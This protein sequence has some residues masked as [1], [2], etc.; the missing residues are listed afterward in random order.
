MGLSALGARNRW[1]YTA[2]M[3]VHFLFV[4]CQVGSEATVK[5][6]IARKHPSFRFAFSRRGFLTFR[7]P[8]EV[9]R[10]RKFELNCV[11]AR[12]WG[13][14]F[15]K[16]I[17]TDGRQL[18]REFWKPFVERYPVDVLSQFRHLHV[19]QRDRFVP[20]DSDFEP[21]ITPL[22]E[23]IGELILEQQPDVSIADHQVHE[24]VDASPRLDVPQKPGTSTLRLTGNSITWSLALNEDANV[25]DRILDCVI[26]EPNE[27]WFGWH[28]ANAV[29]TRW[30]GGVPVI[31]SPDNMISRAYLKIEEALRWSELPVQAGDR[32]VEVGSSPGGS[33]Q[34]L[35]DR[36][37]LVTGID[38]AEMDPLL[39]AN[40]NF[41]HLRS[42][43][44]KVERNDF[45]SFRWL[46]MDANVAPKYTL[47]TVE[48]IVTQPS[49][50]IEGLLL[51]LKLTDLALAAELPL[52]HKR[53]RSWGY[54]RVR[55]RQLAFNRQE[56]CVVAT[57]A[58]MHHRRSDFSND[59]LSQSTIAGP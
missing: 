43:A 37:C 26:V 46:A 19:W 7:I 32:F 51:T 11:F 16:A 6:E 39:L 21:G 23:G 18:A 20:G 12:T 53:I 30:P 24:P 52:F 1:R 15:G 5:N 34:A 45:Q 47:D 3:S 13:F 50:H 44:K 35:L 58:A 29:E 36:G 31:D 2:S 48:A 38:P 4:V 33:C 49:V 41:T 56:V 40:P 59:S 9:A 55:A 42:R 27:W 57:D 54:R 8:D 10:D 14:S 28:R 22:A 25:D 17:G